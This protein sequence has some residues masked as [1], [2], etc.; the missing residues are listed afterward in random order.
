MW[1][2]VCRAGQRSNTPTATTS[3]SGL[4]NLDKKADIEDGITGRAGRGG[5]CGDASSPLP[6]GP[7]DRFA[8][9]QD[10][11]DGSQAADARIIEPLA[12]ESGTY[13][14]DVRVTPAVSEPA[15]I[16]HSSPS[17]ERF[18]EL[19]ELT[20]AS[21]QR[22]NPR[23]KRAL[24]ERYQ[25]PVLALVS[26]MLKGFGDS[27]LVEDVAQETFL[28]VFRALP[29]YDRNGPARLSTWI[30]TIASHRSIDE[31]RRRRLETR[32]LDPTG[33]DVEGDARADE[34]AERRMLARLIERAVQSLSPE[35]RAAFVLREYHGLEYVEIA[36]ALSIDLGTV[37]SRLNRARQRLRQSLVEVYHAQ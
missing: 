4:Q 11:P 25:R 15:P 7:P 6:G 18:P 30:L 26:R 32:P 20:L 12:G 33:G 31:L 21:A 36:E 2:P 34:A 3:P 37:K 22:G 16:P 24:V 35:Y 29:S 19:D 28:R 9:G 27:G 5:F 8:A 14:L 17:R 13:V 1:K 10:A 23:A